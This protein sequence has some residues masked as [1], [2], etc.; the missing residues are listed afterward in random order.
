MNER[1]LRVVD[2]STH[3]SGPMASRHLVHFGADV[4]KVEDPT[5]GDGNRGFPPLAHGYGI[6]HLSLNPGTRSLA[7]GRHSPLWPATTAALARWADVAIVGNR[8]ETATKLGIDFASMHRHNAALVYC[9]ISGYG[10]GGEWASMPAHGL[11]MDAL[12]GAMPLEWDGEVPKIPLAYRSAG[13]TLAGI[14]AALGIYAALYQRDLDHSGQLVHVSIWESALAWMWR[15]TTTQANAGRGWTAYQDMGPRYAAYAAGDGLALL[16]CPIE[17]K[18]WER[19]CDVV[20]LPVEARS[21][22][23]WHGG[24][25]AG[26]AYEA[27]GERDLIQR[28]LKQRSRDEWLVAF[29]QADVPAAPILDCREA[30]MSDHALAN[31]AMA[32]YPLDDGAVQVPTVPISVTQARSVQDNA[33]WHAAHGSKGQ[34]LRPPPPLGTDTSEI[35]RDLGIQVR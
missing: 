6:Q 34:Q 1:R 3:I 18:F 25:D 5:Q 9:L 30:M 13:T 10:L 21:R 27:L 7:L 15:D 11:N 26:V 35:L 2:F 32:S 29:R 28:H 4:I 14:H 19:F 8:P 16:V 31:G 33:S 22:G 24:S 17:Q 20:G 12:A 23:D